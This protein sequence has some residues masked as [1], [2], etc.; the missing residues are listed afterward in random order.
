MNRPAYF[1]LTVVMEDGEQV[2]LTSDRVVE[3]RIDRGFDESPAM[4]GDYGEVPRIR[5][6]SFELLTF[7]A[8]FSR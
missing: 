1:T 8:K 4:V 3:A 2:Q 6:P 7:K 5:P